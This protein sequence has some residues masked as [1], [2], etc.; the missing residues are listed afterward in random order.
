MNK[1]SIGLGS[2]PGVIG[3]FARAF[4]LIELLVVIAIIAILAAMLLPA[5]ALAKCKAQRTYCINNLRQVAIAVKM[6]ADDN[7]GTLPASYPNFG[8]F[9]ATWC[10]GNADTRVTQGGAGSYNY[11]GPDPTGIER[12][13]LFPYTKNVALYHC[14]ADHRIATDPGLPARFRGQDILRSISMNCYINGCSVGANPDWV[15]TSPNG[16]MDPRFPVMRKETD[17]RDPVET[18]LTI[19]EDQQSIDDAMFVTDVTSRK[20]Y[21]LPS[22]NHC[23][24]RSGIN[25]YDGHSELFQLK[26]AASLGWVWGQ[27]GGFNDWKTLTNVVTHPLH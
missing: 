5:L 7:D 25:F 8:G 27:N 21:N 24:G 20:F 17:V 12:G 23:G 10:D 4:T 1:S 9:T 6:Y 3:K 26:D 14:P 19:D 18:F 16:Q 2:V 22:R 11:A 15:V 13:T